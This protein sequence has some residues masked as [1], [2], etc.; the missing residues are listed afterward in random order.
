MIEIKVCSRQ[1]VN[2]QHPRKNLCPVIEVKT[3]ENSTTWKSK[4][5]IGD[6]LYDHEHQLLFAL[7]DN[8]IQL[9]RSNAP[10]KQLIALLRITESYLAYHF[11]SEE[12]AM[13]NAT[14]ERF[15]LHKAQ[16]KYVLEKISADIADLE[17][18]QTALTAQHIAFT[19]YEWYV[20]HLALED[21]QLAH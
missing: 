1:S 8:C 19:L 2:L 4:F 9:S 16:H 11:N 12:C 20:E 18:N 5:E 10:K 17:G 3:I 13:G 15:V 21:T 6:S 14:D 7:I